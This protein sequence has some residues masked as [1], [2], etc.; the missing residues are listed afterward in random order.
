MFTGMWRVVGNHEIVG[1]N[2]TVL[3]QHFL[4]HSG[5]AKR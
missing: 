5:V 1:S 4:K 2:P 3:T